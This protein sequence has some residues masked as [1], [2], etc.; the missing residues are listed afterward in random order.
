TAIVPVRD[1][2]RYL[3]DALRSIL[4]QERP[5]DEIIVVDDGSRDESAAIARSI[6][7][8]RCVTQRPAGAAAARKRA[9]AA[10]SGAP[11]AFLDAD[12][13]WTADKLRLQV[14]HL[15]AH[16]EIDYV[17]AHQRLH[18]EPGVAPPRWVRAGHSDEQ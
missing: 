15:A 1:G 9:T 14:G 11:L 13:R 16:P 3:A 4:E 10:A 18:L 5:A 7:G 2:A 8:V 6:S 17:L 12:D